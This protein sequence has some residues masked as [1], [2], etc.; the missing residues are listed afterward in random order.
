ML[1]QYK[2]LQSVEEKRKY[3][4]F[5]LL[6]WRLPAVSSKDCPR[7]TL[8]LCVDK[9]TALN[10]FYFRINDAHKMNDGEKY[11]AI[12]DHCKSVG[13]N[14]EIDAVIEKGLPDFMLM[15]NCFNDID[16]RT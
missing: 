7:I 14:P 13:I 5:L 15:K 2:T 9:V 12:V 8:A 3:T 16:K 6:L 4:V 11:Q 10:S 1:E